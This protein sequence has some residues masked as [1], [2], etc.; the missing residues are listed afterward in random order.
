M[1]LILA[2]GIGFIHFVDAAKALA[3][4]GHSVTV[5]S[6]TFHRAVPG[7]RFK[8][9]PISRVV[10][11]LERKLFQRKTASVA[12]K[13]FGWEASRYIQNCDVAVIRSG[14]GFYLIDKAKQLGVNVVVDHTLAHPN[15]LAKRLPDMCR[16]SESFWAQVAKD[17]GDAGTLIVNS[18]FVKRT[19][20]DEGIDVSKIRVVYLGVRD[21]F[22]NLRSL[23]Q[24]GKKLR[25]L[26]SGRFCRRKGCDVILQACREL[27]M[28]GVEFCL[29][30]VGD[31]HEALEDIEYYSRYDL[32]IVFH[33]HMPQDELKSFFRSADVYV[34]PSVAE[35]CAQSGMEALAA[36]LCVVA[37]EASGLP[38]KDGVTG[39]IVSSGDSKSL[40]DRLE[41]IAR[42][43][44]S[45]YVSYKNFPFTWKSYAE[46]L[47]KVLK[48]G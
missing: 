46:N 48:D 5:V 20:A 3:A 44:T 29:D 4:C 11:L 36:G 7:V 15:S 43:K 47:V 6:A 25:L 17:C 38:I 45:F 37:T 1:R 12:W 19:F 34:F 18:H 23:D 21:D 24:K 8:W 35:G 32:P 13:I 10:D 28:R 9:C 30:V 14:A 22:F 39:Y 2:S 40:A 27:Q 33:G 16:G 31:Y 41:N 42:N 26:F